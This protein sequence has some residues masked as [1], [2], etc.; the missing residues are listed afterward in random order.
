MRRITEAVAAE[1]REKAL[2]TGKDAYEFDSLAPG[3]FLRATPKG[4]VALGAQVRAA[5]RKPKVTVGLWT[6]GMSVADGRELAR[7]A[8]ID[9]REG[10]D[11]ALERRVRQQAAAQPRA[12]PS[13]TSPISG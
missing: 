13:R 3:Y 2:A 4:V 8:V 10:R 12:S 6:K 11:P 7:L 9:L 5:G 1:L